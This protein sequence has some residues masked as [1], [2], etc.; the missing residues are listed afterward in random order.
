MS[1]YKEMVDGFLKNASKESAKEI[2]LL[3]STELT[4]KV[5]LTLNKILTVQFNTLGVNRKL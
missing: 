2:S 4:L 5:F 1:L 3:D